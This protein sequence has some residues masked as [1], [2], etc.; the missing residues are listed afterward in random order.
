VPPPHGGPFHRWDLLPAARLMST[1]VLT[2]EPV[3]SGWDHRVVAKVEL[4]D[5][6]LRQQ[7]NAVDTD[8]H[9]SPL[10]APLDTLG[11][12]GGML[13]IGSPPDNE[14]WISIDSETNLTFL[15]F[16]EEST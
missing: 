5:G 7:T 9:C 16:F 1:H 6:P 2:T 3:M 8:Y 12:G 14:P 11:E 4:H 15:S 13:D 10:L